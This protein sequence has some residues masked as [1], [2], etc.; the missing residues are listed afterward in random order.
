MKP[1][2]RVRLSESVIAAVKEMI[3]EEGFKPD[4]KF[5]SENELTKKLQVS[6]SSV[7]EALRMLEVTGQVSV[8]QGKG[9][10]ILDASGEQ[11]KTFSTWLKNNEQSI[12][13]NFEVRL[14]I[15]PKAAGRAAENSDV[16]D[17]EQMEKVCSQF[18]RFNKDKN[19]EEVI[20]CDR[21]FHRILA[22]ATKNITLHVLMK[23]MTAELPNGWISSLYTPGRIE[24][25]IDEH[26]DILEAIKKRDKTGAENAMTRHLINALH[27]I[28]KQ[29][30]KES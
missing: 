28:N 24:K 11:F 27:D 5:Y 25:T 3:A 9:I 8:K 21:R 1:I 30:S 14:I 16:D 20:Q 29:I 10:F 6:R 7:R 18:A 17:I 19:I 12:K 4:D 23:S 26:G 2:K 13:D 22:G 15:E